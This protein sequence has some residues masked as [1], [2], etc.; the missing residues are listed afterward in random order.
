MDRPSGALYL[1]T[2]DENAVSVSGDGRIELHSAVAARQTKCMVFYAHKSATHCVATHFASV[3]R[4]IRLTGKPKFP[5]QVLFKFG[6]LRQQFHAL[7]NFHH[8]LFALALLAARGG[9]IDAKLL[10]VIE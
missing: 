6:W 8:A 2:I 7:D 5:L 4:D 1:D 10:G 3:S 9:D